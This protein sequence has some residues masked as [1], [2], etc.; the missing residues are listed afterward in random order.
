MSMKREVLLGSAD[1][2][3]AGALA[4]LLWGH[5]EARSQPLKSVPERVIE[6][7]HPDEEK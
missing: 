7:V 2:L 3:A 1:T 6:W 4:W 5:P